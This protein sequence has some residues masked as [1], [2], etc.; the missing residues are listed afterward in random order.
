[1]PRTARSAAQMPPDETRKGF[2]EDYL[3]YLLAR[4]SG[5]ASA[6][7]HAVVKARGLSVPEWRVFGALWSRPMSIGALAEVTLY[8]Q[9]TLTKVIDRMERD[10]FVIRRTDAADGRRTLADL[11][12][13]GRATAAALVPMARDHERAVLRGYAPAEAAALKRALR[14]LIARTGGTA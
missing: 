2:V 4:A 11:T 13:K 1:M 14:I 12:A 6:Q 7:F 3:L 8:Q 10:G 5:Q 9:P